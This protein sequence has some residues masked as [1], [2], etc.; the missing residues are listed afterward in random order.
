MAYQAT[1]MS[2][3]PLLELNNL[4]RAFYGLDVL[5]GVD[6]PLQAGLRTELDLTVILQTTADRAEGVQAFIERREPRFTTRRRG[7]T[8]G[9][10]RRRMRR[11]SAF[12]HVRLSYEKATL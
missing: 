1:N 9:I 5:R 3:M 10:S 6:L 2:L 11:A 7:C 8:G 12:I 4:R